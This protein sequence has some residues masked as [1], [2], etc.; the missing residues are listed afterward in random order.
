M[1]EAKQC[2]VFHISAPPPPL[3]YCVSVGPILSLAFH[4][5]KVRVPAAAALSH[6]L[7]RDEREAEANP[8]TVTF[9]QCAFL[10]RLIL[11]QSEDIQ[12]CSVSIMRLGV[13]ATCFASC[14]S[15]QRTRCE[16][17]AAFNSSFVF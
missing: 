11:P 9:D 3:F 15:L 4:L 14:V 10:T 12:T 2:A 7:E 16:A 17:Q 13:S 6:P 1:Y 8:A 5:L